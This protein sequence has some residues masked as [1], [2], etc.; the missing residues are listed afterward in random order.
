M[1]IVSKTI[2]L[3]LGVALFSSGWTHIQNPI[4]FVHSIEQYQLTN[5]L[6][7]IAIAYF[8]PA[9]MLIVGLNLVLE[10]AARASYLMGGLFFSMFA[11]VQ[12]TAVMRGLL[13]PCGCFGPEGHQVSLFAVALCGSSALFLFAQTAYYQESKQDTELGADKN[14]PPPH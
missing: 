8:L 14:V 12:A 3:C 13:I 4:E 6:T 10:L 11:T 7:S 2:I 9:A 5:K 1:N